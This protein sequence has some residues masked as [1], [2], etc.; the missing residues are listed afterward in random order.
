MYEVMG[1]QYSPECKGDT[2]SDL[3]DKMH[4]RELY[5]SRLFEQF[6]KERSSKIPEGG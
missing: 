4:S 6:F 3:T 1:R 5:Y 2:E